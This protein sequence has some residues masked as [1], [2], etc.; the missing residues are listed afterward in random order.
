MTRL[1]GRNPVAGEMIKGATPAARFN[2]ARL[3]ACLERGIA[4]IRQITIRK[5]TRG[6]V[7]AVAPPH[8]SNLSR[9]VS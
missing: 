6:P 4:E 1:T 3:A 2:V 7:R 8:I 5:A 9:M